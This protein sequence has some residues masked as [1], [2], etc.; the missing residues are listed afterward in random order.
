M[1]CLVYG[2]YGLA[3]FVL[4]LSI[5]VRSAIHENSVLLTRLLALA[6]FGLLHA[7]FEWIVLVEVVFHYAPLA[8]L[9]YFI[10]AVSFV[11]LYW[12][13][14]G[15]LQVGLR[16]CLFISTLS[17]V[18]WIVAFQLI[19]QP[20]VLELFT[21]IAIGVPAAVC[22]SWAF[23]T[24]SALRLRP[25]ALSRLSRLAGL[26]FLVY[27]VSQTISSPTALFPA[28]VL[29]TQTFEAF[30][31]IPIFV[32]RSGIAM[33]VALSVM[34]L[35]NMFDRLLRQNLQEKAA[36]AQ[37]ALLESEFQ[38]KR[39]QQIANMGSWT[40]DLKRDEII[41]SD[42]SF[43]ILG[44]EPDE[45]NAFSKN[46]FEFV[47][48]E[49]REKV[50]AEIQAAVEANLRFEVTYRIVLPN[51]ELRH[52][53][54]CGE[55]KVDD[56]GDASSMMGT[57]QDITERIR[58]EKA[59]K[60]QRNLRQRVLDGT[61]TFISLISSD[62]ILIELN[63]KPIE[64]LGVKPE[65]IIGT[66]LW[67][68]PGWANS[69]ASSNHIREVV[70]RAMRGET[71]RDDFVVQGTNDVQIVVDAMFDPLLDENG[72]VEYIVA[73]AIDV[74]ER[75]QME[76]TARQTLER[77]QEAQRLAKLGSWEFDLTTNLIEA[78]DACYDILEIDQ[79]QS[80]FTY[81]D[82]VCR[83]HPD[84]QDRIANTFNDFLESG[85]SHE[86][87][88][89]LLMPDGRVKWVFVRREF[90]FDD[91]GKPIL[92]RGMIQ[93]ITN[94]KEMEDSLSE[95]RETLKTFLEVS[96]EAV[97]VA[98]IDSRIKVFSSGAETIFGY[99]ASEVVGQP[100][101]CLMPAKYRQVHHRQVKDFAISTSSARKMSMGSE[102]MGQRKNGEE[103]PAEA[104]LSKLQTPNGVFLATIL[105]DV[106]AQKSAHQDLINAKIAAESANEAKSRFIA[107]MSH[108]LRTP[109]NAIIGLSDL[110]LDPE[111]YQL[112]NL[113][114]IDAARDIHDSGKHLLKII[115]DIL[116]ISRIE[117]ENTSLVEEKVSVADVV[118]SCI[119]MLRLQASNAGI[120][121]RSQISADVPYLIADS[122]LLIQ[123]LLN[124]LSNA[125]KFTDSGGEAVIGAQ[126]CDDGKVKLFVYDS[127]IGMA[128][129]IVKRIGEPFLQADSNESRNFDGTGLG[130]A[131]VKRLAELHDASLHIESVLGKGT[132]VY[133]L[134][135][136]SRV[137][138]L[139]TQSA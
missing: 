121:L 26:A 34:T 94:R 91:H 41:L 45:G 70:N 37:S 71:V 109:L 106:S 14:F 126:Y 85:E 80:H 52:I 49:D 122:R 36:A 99:K 128:P 24:D 115:N 135:P 12:F 40:W 97:I 50:K 111:R 58:L 23:V 5:A 28:N 89:R 66:P 93:D 56:D 11:A 125:V 116:D 127:G 15:G 64:A 123:M 92:A 72:Q 98:D 63:R 118:G 103:F 10:A 9:K 83:V 60:T 82:M 53:E 25:Y 77:L 78:S 17:L 8:N 90:V 130:L 129:E 6:V 75:R 51:L 113:R 138:D 112:D 21:R 100:V 18:G 81:D 38:L 119:N 107:T 20:A 95:S 79:A 67:E 69:E 134:M 73:S 102:I 132:R 16:I 62:G 110:L 108:E 120:D 30:V 88:H 4:G 47:Y 44:L 48:E 104:S 136:C 29:N 61:H 27:G 31:G 114:R 96:P 105:R 59:E 7:L 39:A 2:F 117:L 68:M 13:A 35:L 86:E 19:S 22:A 55:F 42:Q 74:T 57:M 1:E 84:D 133:I 3:F 137:A 54:S 65:D 43:T 46:F 124:L 139:A 76:Q 33:V 87:V 101:E 32:V 131:I